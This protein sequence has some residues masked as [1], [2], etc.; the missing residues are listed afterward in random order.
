MFDLFSHE[1]DR[2]EKKK[3][4][5][6]IWRQLAA[7]NSKNQNAGR[8][9]SAVWY[10]G[11]LFYKLRGCH[12][13]FFRTSKSECFDSR[14]LRLLKDSAWIYTQDRELV[15]PGDVTTDS[16]APE[17]KDVSG[18]ERLFE[19]FG[20]R[21]LAS[22]ETEGECDERSRLS[23]KGQQQLEL[24]KQAQAVG[25]TEDDIRQWAKEKK[26]KESAVRDGAVPSPVPN[27]PASGNVASEDKE[28]GSDV[29]EHASSRSS[30]HPVLSRISEGVSKIIKANKD[31]V[32]SPPLPNPYDDDDDD[33]LTPRAIDFGK[34]I[35]RCEQC[36]AMEIATLERGDELQRRALAAERYSF[37]WFKCLL[38]LEMLGKEK[39][40]AFQHEI[41][42]SFTR[43][44]REPGTER[45]FVLK[46]PSREIPQWL[47]ELSGIPL[48]LTVRRQ[49]LRPVIEVMSV[50]AFTLRV[51]LKQGAKMDGVDLARTVEAKIV[52]Q[53]PT[54]LLEALRQGLEALPFDDDR[55]LKKSLPENIEFIFGPPGTGKTT[56]LARERLIPLM[57]RQKDYRVLVLTPTN[58][59]ADV[60]AARV[61]SQMGEDLSYHSWLVRFGATEDECLEKSGVC[62]GKDID[63]R[64]SPRNVMITTIARFPYDFYIPGNAMPQKLVDQEWD[65]IVIDEASMIPLVSIIFAIHR[66][67]TS[68]FIIAG[69]PFQIEPIIAC[70]LWKDENIYTMV[71]LMNFATPTTSPRI[72][73]VVKLTTQYRSI[74][75]VG[76]IFSGYGYGGILGHAR[77]EQDRRPL[78]IEGLID[79]RP[80]TLMKFPVSRY[81][82][83]YRPKRLG[84]NG[85][86]SYQIYSVLFAYEFVCAISRRM[87]PQEKTFR[88]GVISPYRV[89]ADLVQ[90]LV[91]ATPL[92]TH[93]NVSAGTVHGFQ[94]DECEMIVALFNPTPSMSSRKGVFVNKK[95][96]INVAISRARDYLVVLMPDDRTERLENMTEVRKVEFLM[97]ES[98]PDSFAVYEA[99]QVE[100]S[101]FGNSAFIE[102][103]A[104][105]TGHQSVNV[106]GDPEN[107]YE[108]RM[109]DTAVDI[110][111]HLEA[112]DVMAEKG[113][114]GETVPP[115]SN[116]IVT[117]E[118]TSEGSGF[119]DYLS[120]CGRDNLVHASG[121]LQAQARVEEARRS[122]NRSAL[123]IAEFKLREARWPVVELFKR[124]QASAVGATES[125]DE[126]VSEYLQFVSKQVK[127]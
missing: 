28:V 54:F 106:Y 107:R 14:I 81:E 96:I 53:R 43:I 109:D 36:Q 111:I 37:G 62:P 98:N 85:G 35:K 51:K 87:R 77:T 38:A 59:A 83:I 91:E 4:S 58:K 2:T 100:E 110:Q 33:E 97:R 52:A 73:P 31:G 69:D 89:Q 9:S 103:N 32:I 88:I 112:D 127:V 6:L 13:Y 71:G 101:I 84:L 45:T 113:I 15:R 57:K 86:S 16:I 76:R 10:Q 65:Y 120:R 55:N 25:M 93:V 24:G 90:R 78:N 68:H 64:R 48:E 29:I 82:S 63:L 19:F 30:R 80:L 23:I 8:H 115:T 94:G 60:L 50:R 5:L 39:N 3:I 124:Y 21:S 118:L 7:V 26:A 116:G 40:S 41:S 74:P 117:D 123:I 42:I 108:V 67:P 126:A 105:P 27:P 114:L 49:T 11:D 18:V 1:F 72:Y 47:E 75:S 22:I 102:Q 99:S 121:L 122:G 104:F 46:R 17:Y 119:V 44:E 12:S 61:I 95:N 34:Q 56:F 79:I 125:E 66:K 70:E 20:I 92:P